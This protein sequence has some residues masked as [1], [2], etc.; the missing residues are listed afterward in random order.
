MRIALSFLLVL[1]LAAASSAGPA[2]KPLNER[3]LIESDLAYYRH[4]FV[5][6]YKTVGKHDPRWDDAA[7]AFLDRCAVS[8]ANTS[9]SLIVRS[10]IDRSDDTLKKLGEDAAKAGCD[11]PLVRYLAAMVEGKFGMPKHIEMLNAALPPLLDSGYSDYIKF[12]GAVRYAKAFKLGGKKEIADVAAKA[13]LKHGIA[14]LSK[15][16]DDPLER[17]R[18]C[19]QIESA[20]DRLNGFD[21]AQRDALAE[22]IEKADGIDPW[23]V[24]M[25][26][27]I[28]ARDSTF[29]VLARPPG[30]GEE[31]GRHHENLARAHDAFA[32]AYAL[33][34][35][36]PESAAAMIGI[37]AHAALHHDDNLKEDPRDWFDRAIAA[38]PDY[39][40]AWETYADALH[41]GAG[42]GSFDLMYELGCEAADTGQFDT[43][44]PYFLT[45]V[46]DAIAQSSAGEGRSFY[47]DPYVWDHLSAVFDGYMQRPELQPRLDAL[48]NQKLLHAYLSRACGA[49][50]ATLNDLKG[51]PPVELFQRR[52][53]DFDYVVEEIRAMNSEQGATLL[54]AG[55]LATAKNY[56]GARALYVSVMVSP[57]ATSAA[58]RFAGVEARCCAVAIDVAHGGA[59]LPLNDASDLTAWQ[60]I[61]PGW[62]IGQPG[63]LSISGDHGGGA[64]ICH[65]APMP[66]AARTTFSF[67]PSYAKE[68][69]RTYLSFVFARLQED[70]AVAFLGS[71][72]RK[73]R[74][75]SY[76]YMLGASNEAVD[77][78]P[79]VWHTAKIEHIG[80]LVRIWIDGAKDPVLEVDTPVINTPYPLVG[81]GV[82]IGEK[83]GGMR[84]K[85]IRVEAI[86][87][88]HAE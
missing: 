84:V 39:M 19:E 83:G 18:R 74:V 60:T 5:D 20:M 73:V 37:A 32:A 11:D 15:K 3:A 41:P 59:N 86:R 21:P 24:Q 72:P 76:R 67:M 2:A 43:S 87:D 85:D 45:V 78:K 54:A 66:L 23:L 14:W 64:L 4:E 12:H 36:F 34:K 22:G 42:Q 48:R 70:R 51:K 50:L 77:L 44:V 79:D 35:S 62:E 13:V 25:A 1:A 58:Q 28:A 26:V 82:D 40:P 57:G 17:R 8:M 31:E 88:E 71:K 75:Q 52:G 46:L 68:G 63:E 27:G 61:Y 6:A 9:A 65:R 30:M 38:Q 56:V 80:T 16:T 49:A 33:E 81:F 47:R 29:I 10:N 7:I 69:P 53:L 55:A